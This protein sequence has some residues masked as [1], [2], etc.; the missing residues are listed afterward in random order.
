MMDGEFGVDDEITTLTVGRQLNIVD[1][2][3]DSADYMHEGFY[4]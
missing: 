3:C 2:H 4:R 1:R